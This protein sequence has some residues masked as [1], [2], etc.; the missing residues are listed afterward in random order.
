MRRLGVLLL[1][2]SAF[3]LPGAQAQE[4][5]PIT[6]R[7]VAWVMLQHAPSDTD[8][9]GAMWTDKWPT[10]RGVKGADFRYDARGDSDGDLLRA[11]VWPRADEPYACSEYSTCV[12]LA[13]PGETQVILGWQ[14][15]EPEEDP[16]IVF[17]TAIHGT[18]ASTAYYAGPS[19]T[20]DPRKL[21]LP[22]PVET[23]VAIATDPRLRLQTT[24]DVVAAGET[25][26][27]WKGGE[28]DPSQW[29]IVPS[30]HRAQIGAMLISRGGWAYYK[31]V[32]RSP[33]RFAFG[34]GALG[35]RADRRWIA[36]GDPSVID[37]VAS[38]N[39]PRWLAEKPCQDE[40]FAGRCRKFKGKRGPVW[41]FYKPGKGTQPGF[42][43]A[44]Q[45][46]VDQVIAM[47]TQPRRGQI[48]KG[49]RA[50][51]LSVDWWG[52]MERTVKQPLVGVTTERRVLD[53]T[54]E[55]FGRS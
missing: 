32:R 10:L 54:R 24:P 13:G 26:A 45:R 37:V 39:W 46:R 12:E 34:E 42:A 6:S 30:N 20:K 11:Y 53:F 27:K 51:Q 3:A 52:S 18:E 55:Q 47:R 16:G 43:W 41:F 29:D 49:F 8:S 19:I 15:L 14:E 21:D 22:I 7:A 50:A 31:R 2:F 28:Q 36:E 5:V 38:P 48:P 35:G 23:L 25:V 4:L 40:K 9:R 17:V 1:L 44:L 33:Q